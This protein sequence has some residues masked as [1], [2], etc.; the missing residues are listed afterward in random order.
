MLNG[1]RPLRF[2]VKAD[3]SR[4]IT[5]HWTL[6]PAGKLDLL[7]D[8]AGLSQL[9]EILIPAFRAAAG[10]TD[11]NQNGFRLTI[12]LP[13]PDQTEI[14][15]VAGQNAPCLNPQDWRTKKSSTWDPKAPLP[16]HA[17]WAEAAR[18]RQEALTPGGRRLFYV[19]GEHDFFGLQDGDPKSETHFIMLSVRPFINLFDEEITPAHWERYFSAAGQILLALG[20][21]DQPARLTANSGFAFQALPRLHMHVQTA[22]RPLPKLFPQDYGFTVNEAGVIEAPAG[23]EPHARIIGLIDQRKNIAGN[24]PNTT[25]LRKALDQQLFAAL[26]SL[27]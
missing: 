9:R 19:E 2:T 12:D 7:N 25:A 23:S 8:R 27:G 20:L 1:V 13:Q 24:D 5:C 14:H 4:Q 17:A 18:Q 6:K 11:L 21:A 10:I 22:G 16:F 26:D 15:L 3:T